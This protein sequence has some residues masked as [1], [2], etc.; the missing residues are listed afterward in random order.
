MT[1]NPQKRP[2][3]LSFFVYDFTKI[4]AGI[5][6]LI[7][8]RPKVMYASEEA[9][10]KIKGGAILIS[11]HV[12]FL[13]PVY[14]MYAVWYRRHR[15][16]CMK[17]IMESKLGW[18]LKCFH[19][20]PIDREN[21]SMESFREITGH[22]KNGDLISMFPEGHINDGSGQLKA[23]KSGMILMAVKSGVPIIPMY[24]KGRDHWYQRFQ[25]IIGEPV[26]INQMYGNRPSFKQIEEITQY[27]FNQ[28]EELKQKIEGKM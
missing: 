3:R 4:T 9:K 18:L 11:N 20:I 19:C 15:F 21:F 26:D 23:F 14:M 7:W 16:I 10:K 27:L 17:E 5:P 13:D 25:M 8:H 28:E 22:L 2:G 1:N 6:G 24:I 12:G